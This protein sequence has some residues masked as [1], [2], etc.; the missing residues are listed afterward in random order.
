MGGW[1]ADVT[2]DFSWQENAV[3]RRGVHLSGL[4]G[5]PPRQMSDAADLA[6]HFLTR[7]RSGWILEGLFR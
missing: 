3:C 5:A 1:R 4:A 2:Q 6:Q 7:C